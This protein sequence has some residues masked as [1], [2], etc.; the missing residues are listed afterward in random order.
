[1]SSAKKNIF[2][3][4]KK[5][6]QWFLTDESGKITK[7][8]ALGLAA[9]ASL[10]GWVDTVSAA[11][12]SGTGHSNSYSNIWTRDWWG[13]PTCSPSINHASWVI[14]GH[15]SS[16]ISGVV[17]GHHEWSKALYTHWSHGSHGSHSSSWSGCGSWDDGGSR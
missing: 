14:N 15:Y 5:T 6:L 3:K 11:H 17:G 16:N 2:P 13:N 8:D 1:M 4:L 7:K 10:L 12:S 9:W